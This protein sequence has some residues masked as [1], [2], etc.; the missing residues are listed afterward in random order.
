VGASANSRLEPSG[1]WMAIMGKLQKQKSAVG[2]RAFLMNE[3]LRT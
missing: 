2:D 1:S 3:K